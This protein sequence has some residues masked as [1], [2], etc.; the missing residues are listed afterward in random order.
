M[1]Y[2]VTSSF[3][4]TAALLRIGL[5]AVINRPISTPLFLAAII[6]STW[7]GGLRL[8]IFAS[9]VAGATLDYFFVQ[10][11]VGNLDIY[12]HVIRFLLFAVEGSLLSW[13][14]DNLRLAG[15]E[16]IASQAELR[17]LAEQHR[18]V[19]D[20]EQK[21]IAREIHD[22]LGQSLTSL[23]LGIHLVRK[24]ISALGG[25]ASELPVL[26]EIDSLSKQVDGTIG[27]VRR[28]ATELRPSILDDF[29]LVAAIE[30]QTGEFEKKS[31][32]ECIFTSNSP[33]IDLNPEASTA[34]FRIF[35]EALTNIARHAKA[36]QVRVRIEHTDGQIKLAVDDNGAGINNEVM[37]KTRSLGL[38]GMRERAR[39]INGDINVTNSK[40]GGTRVELIAPAS[41]VSNGELP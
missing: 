3:L 14:V 13:L 30:W 11:R 16:I 36:S 2:G 38:L 31:E 39:L 40:D 12:D 28:I 23:K 32:I 37:K 18:S 10:P 17:E 6:L 24:K 1:R 34:I 41:K 21:R 15:D 29:G 8:G 27:T 26:A 25:E 4:A 22:E 7:M 35:Q 19:R 5:A 33:A 20:A 9:V